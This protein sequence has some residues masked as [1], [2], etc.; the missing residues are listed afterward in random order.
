MMLRTRIYRLVVRTGSVI[1]FWVDLKWHCIIRLDNNTSN[2]GA[3]A[4]AAH[5]DIMIRDA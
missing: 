4:A 1:V 3:A 2:S 5:H